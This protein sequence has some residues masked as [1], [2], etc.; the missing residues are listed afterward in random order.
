M[1]SDTE[2]ADPL[3]WARL[4]SRFCPTS[5]SRAARVTRLFANSV[6]VWRKYHAPRRRATLSASPFETGCVPICALTL[7][8][9]NASS[10]SGTGL[11]RAISWS[12]SWPAGYGDAPS[13]VKGMTATA[14]RP[15]GNGQIT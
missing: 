9:D 7:P 13:T 3:A 6:F 5:Y 4:R 10:R 2:S 14:G 12:G 1:R 8:N 15:G 11:K